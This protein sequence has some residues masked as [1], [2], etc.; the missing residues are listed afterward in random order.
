MRKL[1]NIADVA[2]LTPLMSY[3]E[4]LQN[5]QGLVS[6]LTTSCKSVLQQTALRRRAP[7]QI[8]H[9]RKLKKK[10]KIALIL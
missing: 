8:L 1:V 10:S 2:N 7:M 3:C 4:Q 6:Q 9:L 5:L